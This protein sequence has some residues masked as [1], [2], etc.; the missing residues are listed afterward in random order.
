[1][2]LRSA[3]PFSGTCGAAPD[4]DFS[5]PPPCAKTDETHRIS[6]KRSLMEVIIFISQI[7]RQTT[8]G[9]ACQTRSVMVVIPQRREAPEAWQKVA[10][11][12]RLCAP[13]LDQVELS[14]RPEWAQRT[15]HSGHSFGLTSSGPTSM[16]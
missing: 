9:F 3:E 7:V 6:T 2:A 10:R 4:P 8:I 15:K 5:D 12:K 1:M 11:G 16:I 13:P 14:P